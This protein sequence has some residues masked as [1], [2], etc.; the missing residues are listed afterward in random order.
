MATYT[1]TVSSKGLRETSV[2]KLVESLKSTFDGASVSVSKY[3]QPESRADRLSEAEG[4]VQ[5]AMSE[6]ECLKDELQEWYDNLPENFQQ[7]DKGS[8]LE[9]AI[10]NLDSLYSDLENADFGNVEFP[11]MFS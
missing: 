10:S 3:E 2:N 5:D 4:K 11:S 1:I 6:V 9:Y 7:G 8:Q